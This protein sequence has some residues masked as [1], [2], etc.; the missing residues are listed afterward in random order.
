[1]SVEGLSVQCTLSRQIL[2]STDIVAVVSS[3]IAEGYSRWKRS[4]DIKRKLPAFQ[5]GGLNDNAHQPYY[6]SVG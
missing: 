6:G 1:M 3:V 2:C 5:A 4:R